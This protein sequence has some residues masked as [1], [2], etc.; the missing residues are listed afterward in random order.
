MEEVV[1]LV[2]TEIKKMKNNR[3]EKQSTK[4]KQSPKED[5]VIFNLMKLDVVRKERKDLW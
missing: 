4:N 5:L 1:K 2:I 3:F